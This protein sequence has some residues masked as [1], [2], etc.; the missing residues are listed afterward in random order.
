MNKIGERIKRLSVKIDI[1]REKQKG[2]LA[3]IVE[4]AYVLLVAYG[5]EM[6]IC[7]G[8]W[9]ITEVGS[10][11]KIYHHGREVVPAGYRLE[12]LSMTQIMEMQRDLPA[13][14]DEAEKAIEVRIRALECVLLEREMGV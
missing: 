7:V 2:L 11:R 14:V 3:Q 5:N 13:L 4:V 6:P 9:V 1:V 10:D 8:S 12:I